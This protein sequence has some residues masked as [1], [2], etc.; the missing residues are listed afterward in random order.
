[1]RFSE[2]RAF[3]PP[4]LSSLAIVAK[5]WAKS[6]KRVGMAGEV[7]ENCHS[8]QGDEKPDFQLELVIR[9]AQ[10]APPRKDKKVDFC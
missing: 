2:T 5:M 10:E 7:K 1:M 3:A 9:H 8:T 6:R 4:G